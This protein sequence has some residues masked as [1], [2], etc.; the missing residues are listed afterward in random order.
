MEDN[1][2]GDLQCYGI[3]NIYMQKPERT[4]LDLTETQ[5]AEK[6]FDRFLINTYT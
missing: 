5:S 2:N 6:Q 4:L 3:Q 1:F